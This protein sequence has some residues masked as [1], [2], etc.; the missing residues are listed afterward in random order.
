MKK[1]QKFL[2]AERV[3]RNYVVG[4]SVKIWRAGDFSFGGWSVLERIDLPTMLA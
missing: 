4:S 3:N 2:K 1:T